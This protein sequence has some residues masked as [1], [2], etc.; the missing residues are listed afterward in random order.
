MFSSM[1]FFSL[2]LSRLNKT[3]QLLY[4]LTYFLVSAVH[5]CAITIVISLSFVFLS[6]F[7]Q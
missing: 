2:S 7:L 1:L 6:S 3:N 5:V 4:V